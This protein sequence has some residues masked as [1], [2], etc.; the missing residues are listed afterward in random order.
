MPPL[1]RGPTVGL[2]GVK[3]TGRPKPS[4][5]NTWTIPGRAESRFE[6]HPSWVPSLDEPSVFDHMLQL[7]KDLD[8]FEQRGIYA[9]KVLNASSVGSQNKKPAK[10]RIH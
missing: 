10:A 5:Y 2:F 6:M 7:R 3:L 9:A 8:R 1:P 4:L